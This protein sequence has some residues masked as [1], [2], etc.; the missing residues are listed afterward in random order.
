MAQPVA[1]TNLTTY[2]YMPV[3]AIMYTNQPGDMVDMGMMG[4]PLNP[5]SIDKMG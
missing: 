1:M 5:V 4:N 3:G 2:K